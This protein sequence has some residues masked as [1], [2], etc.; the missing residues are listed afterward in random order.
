MHHAVR[1]AGESWC[2]LYG[3]VVNAVVALWLSGLTLQHC[4]WEPLDL[5]FRFAAIFVFFI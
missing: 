3:A 1:G 5:N 4:E 2:I